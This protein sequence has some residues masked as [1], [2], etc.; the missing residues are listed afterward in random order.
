MHGQREMARGENMQ[1]APIECHKTY[2]EIRPDSDKEIEFAGFAR[3]LIGGVDL[4]VHFLLI[5]EMLEF[6]GGIVL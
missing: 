3:H 5:R 1:I 2:F 4:V 6:G